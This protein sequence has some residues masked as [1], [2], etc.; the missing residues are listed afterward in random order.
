MAVAVAR[1]A[2][3]KTIIPVVTVSL[4]VWLFGGRF[5]E[6]MTRSMSQGAMAG[7]GSGMAEG[8]N[9]GI[10]NA[11]NNIGQDMFRKF[12]DGS[13][14]SELLNWDGKQIGEKFGE[15]LKNFLEGTGG[16]A[17]I[18]ALFKTMGQKLQDGSF[19]KFMGQTLKTNWQSLS[20]ES[21]FSNLNLDGK[22]I[23]EKIGDFVKQF[24]EGTGAK[25][26]NTDHFLADLIVALERA[27]QKAD[28]GRATRAFGE[29]LNGAGHGFFDGMDIGDM[30]QKVG[31]EINE[32]IK[33]GTKG[34]GKGMREGLNN[35]LGEMAKGLT[36]DILPYFLIASACTTS[37]PL[38]VAYLYYKAKHNIG[39][40]KLATEVHQRTIFT[41]LTESVKNVASYVLNNDGRPVYNADISRRIAEISQSTQNIRKNGGYFQNVLFYGPGGTGKTMISEFIAKNSGMSYVKMSGGDLAQYIKRGEHVTELNKLLDK[42]TLSWRPWSSRPWILFIDEAE[43]LCRDRDK[44]P[45]AE[46]LELQ[47]A[48]LNRTGTQSKKFM[49][50]LSTNRMEDLDEAILSRMDHKIHIGP[51]AKPERI[52]IIKQYVPHFF[53][54]SERAEFFSDILVDRMAE[55]TEGL[56]GRALF[57]LLNTIVNKKASIES[58]KLSQGLIDQAIKDFVEQEKEMEKRRE[59]KA[60]AHGLSHFSARS[61]LQA[62]T[63]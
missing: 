37:V 57:K 12:Q 45:T 33:Q 32:G 1:D 5:V 21:E 17:A 9:R 61:A 55:R 43:S 42:M 51:P 56:T 48:F 30:G 44:I 24:I 11:V 13:L 20:Q 59:A 49:I 35:T 22:Q 25:N 2:F 39:R 38:I 4:P 36:L 16:E 46:L 6:D 50:I 53:S 26:I 41:P 54:R 10:E 18:E 8:L 60:K 15:G 47:N 52:L 31:D 63:V 7:L 28:F 58:A 19:G 29:Q 3:L 34:V 40:P 23:G 14:R 62:K 27:I